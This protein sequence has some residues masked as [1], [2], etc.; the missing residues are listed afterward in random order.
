MRFQAI[1]SDPVA[2]GA[3]I[4][5]PFEGHFQRHHPAQ[6]SAG[7]E[8]QLADP[9]SVEE[10][11]LGAGLV[12]RRDGRE[13]RTVLETRVRVPGRWSRGAV[14]A[15]EQVGAQDAEPVRVERPAGADEGRPPITGRIGG[16]GERMDD[17]D[18]GRH[19]RTRP[20]VAIGHGE[21][22]ERLAR[23]EVEGPERHGFDAPGLDR[24]A[25]G[26]WRRLVRRRHLRI[27]EGIGHEAEPTRSPCALP[28]V[29]ARIA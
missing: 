8:C 9:E 1:A 6:R 16:T 10:A 12:A 26:G 2:A 15:A 7:D 4:G 11:P 29:A 28:S 5:R 14:A 3:A 27:G 13:G 17:E 19:R 20:I 18:L 22:G 24:A 25:V 23:F 21:R